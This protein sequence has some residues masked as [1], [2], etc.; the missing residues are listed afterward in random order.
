MGMKAACN[1]IK[2]VKKLIQTIISDLNIWLGF[3]EDS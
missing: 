1:L 3:P 2:Q